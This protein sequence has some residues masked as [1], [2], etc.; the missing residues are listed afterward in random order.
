MLAGVSLFASQLAGRRALLMRS[1]RVGC[2]DS[3]RSPLSR[4]SQRMTA[5]G[6]GIAYLTQAQAQAIDDELMG[7]EQGFS[8][9]GPA[10]TTGA[11]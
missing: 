6:M 2:T 7:A 1:L 5:G 10:K 9:A 4:G 11:L 8:L 3:G